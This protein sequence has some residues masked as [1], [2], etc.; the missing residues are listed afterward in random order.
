MINLL[1]RLWNHLFSRTP[2]TDSVSKAWLAEHRYTMRPTNPRSINST[3][4]IE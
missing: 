2:S 4:E 3:D 1:R